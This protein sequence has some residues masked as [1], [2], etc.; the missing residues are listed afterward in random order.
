MLEKAASTP[1]I[2]FE[3]TFKKIVMEPLAD[4]ILNKT[5]SF[6]VLMEYR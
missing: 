1:Y 3:K 2:E 5:V 6:K 4:T